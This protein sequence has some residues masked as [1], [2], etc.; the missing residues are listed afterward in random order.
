MPVS[1]GRRDGGVAGLAED[2]GVSM[3]HA[4]E[5]FV[6]ASE[7]SDRVSERLAWI[8][9]A[10]AAW[11]GPPFAIRLWNGETWGT[12]HAPRALTVVVGA[13]SVLVRM[14]LGADLEAP[15]DYLVAGRLDVEGDL[16]AAFG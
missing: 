15:G 3:L 2:C 7:R 16:L 4:E 11:S 5:S 8:A 9:S 14:A 12:S 10:C 1:A 13:P 6:R